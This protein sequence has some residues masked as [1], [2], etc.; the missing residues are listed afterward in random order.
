MGEVFLRGREHDIAFPVLPEMAVALGNEHEIMSQVG[1]ALGGA[2]GAAGKEHVREIVAMAGARRNG[3]RTRV[4][5][6]RKRQHLPARKRCRP[7]AAFPWERGRLAR[8]IGTS[9]KMRARRPRSQGR[10]S[11]H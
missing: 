5:D 1:D 11:L 3:G 9:E 8:S 4:T 2:G 6:R 10:T 7:L